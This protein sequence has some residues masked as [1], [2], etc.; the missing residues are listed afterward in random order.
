MSIE[1]MGT[2]KSMLGLLTFGFGLSAQAGISTS[3][4]W[5]CR[6]E[7]F[8]RG[9]VTLSCES[10]RHQLSVPRSRLSKQMDDRLRPGALIGLVLQSDE[11]AKYETNVPAHFEWR[12]SDHVET[13]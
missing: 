11:V 10:L 7:T 6:A 2:L 4:E 12:K 3:A 5:G 8:D 9:K 13:R 1:K